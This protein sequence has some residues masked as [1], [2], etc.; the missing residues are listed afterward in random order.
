MIKPIDFIKE[1]IDKDVNESAEITFKL[2]NLCEFLD[3]Y[4]K[5]QIKLLNLHI[6]SGSFCRNC[7]E[8]TDNATFTKCIKCGSMK[9]YR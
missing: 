2:K 3:K 4:Y 5:Q 1:N 9:N 7:Q 8:T 6:V